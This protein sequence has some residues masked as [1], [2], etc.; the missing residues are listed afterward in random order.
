MSV[1]GISHQ[2]HNAFLQQNFLLNLFGART[3]ASGQTQSTTS[4]QSASASTTAATATSNPAQALQTFMQTLESALQAQSAA[5]TTAQEASQTTSSADTGTVTPNATTLNG[6]REH[7]HH[8]DME[9]AM[10]SLISEL[11]TAAS[12]ASGTAAD[13]TATATSTG[14]TTTTTTGTGTGTAAAD[15]TASSGTSSGS[16]AL[17]TQLQQSYN[18]LVSAIGGNPSTASLTTFLNNI[19]SGAPQRLGTALNLSA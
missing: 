10:Q 11:G 5:G 17:I 15:T 7:H 18:N 19:A 4:A 9:A 13:S 12:G 2:S 6:L 1:N 8:G 16:N 3:S 14:T